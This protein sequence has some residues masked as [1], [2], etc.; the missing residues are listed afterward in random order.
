MIAAVV[1]ERAAYLVAAIRWRYIERRYRPLLP[2]AMDGDETALRELAQCPRRR[3]VA[4]AYLLIAP[5]IE[6][7]DHELIDATRRIAHVLSI[8]ETADRY[9]RSHRWWRRAVALRVF[10]LIQ[11]RDRTPAIVAALD[12][13]HPDVRAAAL[14]ALADLRDPASVSAIVV[15]LHDASLDRAR[16]IAALS[17]F[18]DQA[19]TFILDVA[20]VDDAHRLNYARSLAMCGTAR[21]RPALC[22]WTMD[23]R[24][25]VRAAS[26]A[27]LEQVGLDSLSA[28]RALDALEDANEQ[29]RATA[30]RAL[31]GWPDDRAAARLARHVDD[32]WAV[33]LPAARAL[34][35]MGEPGDAE[36]RTLAARPDLAGLLARQMLWHPAAEAAS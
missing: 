18:G 27:A 13:P 24:P 28:E 10:G 5:L 19:E 17:A 11:A 12:D 16:R 35:A 31:K 7:R 4:V 14:D 33:A 15:R 30:A 6:D 23:E 20:A 3:R 22:R 29:V 1:I 9:L 25:D 26:F 32:A 21:A 2:R 36:L 8:P 34:Q